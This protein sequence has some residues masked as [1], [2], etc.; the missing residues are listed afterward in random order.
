[1]LCLHVP[2]EPSSDLPA[3]VRAAA[4][5]LRRRVAARP[6]WLP[7]RG[8]SMQP[9]ILDGWEV[10]LVP[11]SRPRRGEVWAFCRADGDIVVHRNR[12]FADGEFVFCGDVQQIAD[13]PVHDDQLIGRVAAIRGADGLRKVTARAR[14]VWRARHAPRALR[15]R[16]ERRFF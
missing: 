4:A 12:Q 16:L 13:D 2:V 10:L 5:L 9:S 15:A 7:V 3:E 8:M 1:M 6:M 14:F 11:A